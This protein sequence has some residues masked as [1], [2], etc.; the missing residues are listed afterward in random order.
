MNKFQEVLLDID[1]K[2][3]YAE[4]TG[5]YVNKKELIQAKSFVELG[6]LVYTLGSGEEDLCKSCAKGGFFKCGCK[7][8]IMLQGRVLKCE[9]HVK[10]GKI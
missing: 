2:I 10:H 3:A 5:N 6:E 1:G 7:P 8:T 4:S 9:R